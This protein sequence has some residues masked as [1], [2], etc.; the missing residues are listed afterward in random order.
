VKP[1]IIVVVIE[2]LPAAQDAALS[3]AVSLAHWYGADLHAAYVRP[4]NR[5]AET[6]D[7]IREQIAARIARVADEGATG[8]NAVPAVLAGAPVHAIAGYT[9]RLSADLVVVGS[10]G[11]R[12]FGYWSKGSFAAALGKAVKAP[13]IAIPDDQQHRPGG[14]ARSREGR[15]FEDNAMADGL[16]RNILAAIDFSDVSIRALTHALVVA[17]QNQGRLRLLHV[18]DGYPYESVYSGSRAFRLMDDLRARVARTNRRLQSLIPSDAFNWSEID[19]ATVSGLGD[20]AILTAAAEHEA[21]LVVLGLPRRSRM[22]DVVAGSTVHRVLR[23]AQL[24]VLLVPD[25]STP[26]FSRVNEYAAPY[27]IHPGAVPFRIAVG[28]GL[29]VEGRT[30]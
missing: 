4:S 8:V 12:N 24:P 21:D 17:Q 16:F 10:R 26:R 28:A 14:K 27:D 1:G 7:A 11:R 2:S 5:T 6:D 9:E 25:P 23:R 30:R 18:L 15:A 13:T 20:E 19:V 3:S 22:E 29:P